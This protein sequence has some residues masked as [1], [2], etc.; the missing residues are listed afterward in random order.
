MNRPALASTLALLAILALL[1]VAAAAGDKLLAPVYPGSVAVDIPASNQPYAEEYYMGEANSPFARVFLSKDPIEKVRAFYE[2]K[3]GPMENKYF[4]GWDWEGEWPFAYMKILAMAD[5]RFDMSGGITSKVP[6]GV[7][8]RA[9]DPSKVLVDDE[10]YWPSVGPFFERLKLH[11]GIGSLSQAEYDALVKKYGYL[12]ARYYAVG[13]RADED[14]RRMLMDEAI[15]RAATDKMTAP[16]Q[17][18]SAVEYQARAQQLMAEGRYE[19]YAKLSEQF[20]AS[21][22]AAQQNSVGPEGAKMLK[23]GLAELE[24]NAYRTLIVIH[25]QLSEWDSVSKRLQ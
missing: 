21:M 12:G 22:M 20:S 25:L 16:L 10:I 13:K 1:P 18:M 3:L 8:I 14:G 9:E 19:E 5:E 7:E 24:R 11:A 2:Q 23:D 17:Q 4:T 6:A 15:F